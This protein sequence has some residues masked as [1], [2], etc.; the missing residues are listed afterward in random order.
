MAIY[1]PRGLPKRSFAVSIGMGLSIM[2]KSRLYIS[3][4]A[5]IALRK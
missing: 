1:K 5:S 3:I 4:Y 2:E